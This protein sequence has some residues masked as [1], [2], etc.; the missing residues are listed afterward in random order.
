MFF[1]I[2][3]L[4]VAISI[5]IVAAYYS[6][7][8]LTAIFAAAVIPIVIMGIV[9]EVGKI[10]AT[11]WL[12]KYWDR[13]N[14]KFKAYLVPAIAILMI[15]TSMGIFGF[16]SKAHMDQAVPAGDI[17]A[18][19]QIFD[20]KIKTEQGN[21]AANKKALEQMDAQV[22]QLLSRTTDKQ[23]ANRAVQI[24]KQQAKERKALQ[25]DIASAQKTI[26]ALQ[27]ERAPIAAE[28][29]K[30]EAE[31]GPIK[32]IAA[33]IYGDNPDT[34]TLEKAV[35]WV[36]IMLVFVFDPLALILILA[37]EQSLIWEREDKRKKES[38][39]IIDTEKEFFESG[40]AIA[41][42]LDNANNLKAFDPGTP[43]PA[44][45]ELMS[46]SEFDK[47]LEDIENPPPP[48]AEAKAFF[49]KYDTPAELELVPIEEPITE[50]VEDP[51]VEH[52]YLKQPWVWMPLNQYDT[53]L[54]P[55][56]EEPV[57]GETINE[58]PVLESSN[59]E[60]SHWHQI[61]NHPA[62]PIPETVTGFGSVLPENPK[63]GDMFLLTST[64]PS[65]L[66]KW[67][68]RKWIDVDKSTTDR[69]AYDEEYIKY[70]ASRL[71]SGEYDVD[72]L[73]PIEQEQIME[74]LS[75]DK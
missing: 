13:A 67:N 42:A 10:T 45:Q 21:I 63:F 2:Y 9:L 33:L 46:L 48:S 26:S 29:R 30:V 7:A 24:R 56:V 15:I 23:G 8:G 70:L 62:E 40:K 36:I 54:D 55:E 61:N 20:D 37:G 38:S 3:I 51:K 22:D 47:V 57:V 12:H 68:S 14:K 50:T 31:V 58:L 5:S 17:A 75:K 18:K 35:R 64:I 16:L 74:Y 65:K 69:Y 49:K 4:I 66:V 25:E 19:V 52:A 44:M 72:L 28:V 43:T 71:Q 59:T 1:A 53:V 39:K 41:R 60:L 73:T 6:I 27:T 32:Y 11:I 34:N